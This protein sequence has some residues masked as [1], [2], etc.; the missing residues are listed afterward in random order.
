MRFQLILFSVLFSPACIYVGE[1]PKGGLLDTG[2]TPQD[3]VVSERLFM[4]TP[5][6]I[7]AE[8]Q[9][10][11]VLEA[12]PDMDFSGVQDVYALGDAEVI[13]FRSS[14]NALH[15][16][17]LASESAEPSMV[18]LVMDLGNEQME[19]ARDILAIERREP[20]IPP[21]NED[22]TEEEREPIQ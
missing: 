10:L 14:P 5:D 22:T 20:P 9:T 1:L 19:V 15:L 8:K 21:E 2:G 12:E 7:E 11:V 6:I 18:H 13:A 16:M 17:M 3:E 4:A